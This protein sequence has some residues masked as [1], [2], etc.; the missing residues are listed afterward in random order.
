MTR[1][2]AKV[3]EVDE[4]ILAYKLMGDWDPN[5]ITFHELILEENERIAL[6]TLS[7]LFGVCY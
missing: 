3:T 5:T 1:A 4:D 7:V 2:L 6:Q